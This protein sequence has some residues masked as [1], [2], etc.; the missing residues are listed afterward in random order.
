MLSMCYFDAM[1]FAYTIFASFSS[2]YFVKIAIENDAY[3]QRSFLLSYY[4]EWC[5]QKSEIPTSEVLPN[6]WASLF[7]LIRNDIY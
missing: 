1:L 7:F 4:K 2:F 5:F 6:Q 3:I